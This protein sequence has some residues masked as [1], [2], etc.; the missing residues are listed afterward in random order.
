MPVVPC[1]GFDSWRRWQRPRQVNG[2]RLPIGRYVTRYFTSRRVSHT[3]GAFESSGWLATKSNAACASSLRP[4]SDGMPSDWPYLFKIQMLWD[5]CFEV[6]S[7]VHPRY[8]AINTVNPCFERT[9]AWGST[10][11]PRL[12]T[13]SWNMMT[14]PLK[15]V[16]AWC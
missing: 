2:H 14:V 1:P 11:H 5:T 8:S 7:S 6:K 15:G 9:M 16:Y 4:D 3:T 13:S 10:T 12:T